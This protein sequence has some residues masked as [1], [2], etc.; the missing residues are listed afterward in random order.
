MRGCK[1][2][3]RDNEPTSED[4]AKDLLGVSKAKRQIAKSVGADPYSSNPALQEELAR[5]AEAAVAGGI[6]GS[7]GVKVPGVD[8]VAS[9]GSLAWDLPPEDLKARNQKSL[10]AMGCDDDTV[11]KLLGSAAFSPSLGTELVVALE[12]LGELKD[13]AALVKLAAGAEN[14]AEARFYRSSVNLLA[15]AQSGGQ[16]LRKA[17]AYGRAP[18]ALAADSTLV[19]AAAVDLLIWHEGLKE[20]AERLVP[21]ATGR[22]LWLTGKLSER[23]KTELESGGWKVHEGVSATPKSGL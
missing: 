10:K 5:L 13:R 21:G 1:R 3:E 18:A 4:K 22:A 2:R 8:Q 11:E 16:K 19:V 6:T 20:S 7:L 12:S 17:L 14:E 23:A 15:A 9:M